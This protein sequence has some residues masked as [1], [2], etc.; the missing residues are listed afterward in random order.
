M[1]R[2]PSTFRRWAQ[3]TSRHQKRKVEPPFTTRCNELLPGAARVL[4]LSFLVAARCMGC[5]SGCLPDWS[6]KIIGTNKGKGAW[7]ASL[8][9]FGKVLAKGGTTQ[10]GAPIAARLIGSHGT[11]G[12]ARGPPALRSNG[13]T[14]CDALSARRRQST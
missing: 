4:D 12:T 7:G 1:C 2:I 5:P 3:H 8:I 13:S 6:R 9:W 11:S 10:G 14:Q